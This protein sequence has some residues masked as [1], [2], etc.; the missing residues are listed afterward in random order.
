MSGTGNGD[1]FLRTCAAHA[2][3]ALARHKPLPASAAFRAVVGP[4]G[5]L[6]RS[7]GDRWGRTGEGEGGMIGVECVVERDGRG[8]RVVRARS[9]VLMDYNCGGM[10]RA[11]ID[12]EGEA[13]MSIWTNGSA[14][15]DRP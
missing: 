9:E 8:G 15:R 14:D 11:W 6:Q 13:V 1:S 4:G 3:A 2:V 5:E 10:Y 12:D 7:A